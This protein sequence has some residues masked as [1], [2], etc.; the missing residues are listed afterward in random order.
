MIRLG[1]AAATRASIERGGTGSGRPARI[2]L[3]DIS[4]SANWL[5]PFPRVKR[6]GI[7]RPIGTVRRLEQPAQ[8]RGVREPVSKRLSAPPTGKMPATSE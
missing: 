1:C 3:L 5:C 6:G 2:E 7:P 8:Y 4:L